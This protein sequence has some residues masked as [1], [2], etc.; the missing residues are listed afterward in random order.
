MPYGDIDPSQH[1]ISQWYVTWRYQDIALTNVDPSMR[2]CGILLTESNFLA[3]ATVAI[4]EFE[5][6]TFKIT[7]LKLLPYFRED[8]GLYNGDQ[9]LIIISPRNN[10]SNGIWYSQ[11]TLLSQ[12]IVYFKLPESSCVRQIM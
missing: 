12:V 11:Q 9:W 1:W 3:S 2:F 8:G 6:Y 4:D 10:L 7:L 5:N